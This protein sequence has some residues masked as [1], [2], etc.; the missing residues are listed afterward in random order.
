MLNR[1]L[2]SILTLS[3]LVGACNLTQKIQD[4]PTAYERKQY[5]LA[6]KLLKKEYKKEKSR[7]EQ[8]KIAFLL[9]D[10]Y[11]FQ[12]QANEAIDWYRIAY[13][14]QYG[15]DALKQYA[16]TL[17]Q[18]ERYQEAAQAFKELGIE[19]GSPYEYRKEITACKLAVEWQKNNTGEYQVEPADFN[20]SSAEYA[21]TFYADG[22]LV[23]TSDRPGSTGDKTYNW[24]GNNFS[25]LYLVD[26]KTQ[27]VKAFDAQINSELNE[28]TA[29]FNDDYSI[30]YFSRCFSGEKF[31]DNFC[32]LMVSNR[33]GESWTVPAV[34]PFVEDNVNYGS[35][36]LSPDGK[37]LYFSANH[38]EGWGG[39]DL[40]FAE[41][42][43]ADW[44]EPQLMSRAINT[45]E[46]EQFPTLD[47]DTLYFASSG[48]T[49]MGGLDIYRTYQ[50]N[51][52]NWAPAQNLK[53]PLNSGS[54]DFGIVIDPKA[55]NKKDILQR[56]YL[57]SNRDGSDDIFVFQ[58]LVPPTPPP[59]PPVVEYQFILDGYL[60]EKIYQV[61]NDPNSK[62]LG[63]KP[64]RGKVEIQIGE[65]TETV[66]VE[67]DGYF[68][69]EL[70]EN[71]TYTF[72]GSSP[73]YLTNQAYFSTLGIGKD[74]NNPVQRFEVEIVLDR[75][76]QDQEIT[77]E[78]IYYDF[79]RWEIRE[80]AQPTLNELAE[81]LKL[82]PDIR[83]QLGSH[84]DCRGNDRYNED[85]SQKRAESAVDY[86]I[87]KGI[88]PDRLSA[89][90][91]GENN[92]SV[93]CVCTRCSEEEHQQNRRTTFTIVDNGL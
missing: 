2:L 65:L 44:G 67:E 87:S 50:T 46:D 6:V 35:P 81:N 29:A 57:T 13:D 9:A 54:D 27:F 60:L 52:T 56:G 41:W 85:L 22:Q 37:R 91:F 61:P 63:R 86:L 36:A 19:I 16:Y 30:V 38:P 74:P 76:F 78:N 77:L 42:E 25:D 1:F 34:L 17:K 93:N 62:V 45:P 15:S 3:L 32:K 64:L 39:Y 7:V 73:G 20:T 70:K 80:D 72:L 89:K 82:N 10:S 71:K 43:G 59:P 58:K 23:I 33:Q 21:P 83:I 18:A 88:E 11:R 53:P 66:Q 24:T 28:G 69:L 4:G 26:P 40:Y 75:I 55:P 47:G 8:G 79:D 31:G 68:T 51:A 92:P 49:G 12:G 90:G 48:H 5:D 84:T 14:N